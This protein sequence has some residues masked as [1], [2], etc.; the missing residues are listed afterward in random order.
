MRDLKFR[1]WTL[2]ANGAVIN[3]MDYMSNQS[4]FE[5]EANGIGMYIM[6]YS[7]VKD[8]NGKDI[9]EGDLLKVFGMIYQVVFTDGAFYMKLKSA[10]HRL[11]RVFIIQEEI[12]IVGNIHENPELL[13]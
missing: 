2:N 7:G 3:R 6:Q 9:Y 11:S 8:K 4:I 1:S 5:W 10:H 13:K 12:E